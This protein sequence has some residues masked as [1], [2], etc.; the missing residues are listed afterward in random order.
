VL[1][2][3]QDDDHEERVVRPIELED[4]QNPGVVVGRVLSNRVTIPTSH[5][6]KPNY[7]FEG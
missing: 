2:L 6:I 3:P 1:A 7:R 4:I 5:L